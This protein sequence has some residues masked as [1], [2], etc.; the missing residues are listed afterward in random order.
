MQIA[1]RICRRKG[2]MN[3]VSRKVQTRS[4]GGIGVRFAAGVKKRNESLFFGR[5]CN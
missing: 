2:V 4:P 1:K 3:Y 5:E